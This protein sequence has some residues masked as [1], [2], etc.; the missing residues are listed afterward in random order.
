MGAEG[1]LSVSTSM[2]PDARAPQPISA[3]PALQRLIIHEPW[4]ANPAVRA[5][6]V[7]EAEGWEGHR[8]AFFI[9][10]N[11]RCETL[12]MLVRHGELHYCRMYSNYAL[13]AV[14]AV[15]WAR[16]IK[17]E[18]E[19]DLLSG[20]G[21]YAN[22]QV[23]SVRVVRR[24]RRWEL[25]ITHGGLIPLVADFRKR[26]HAQIAAEDWLTA[27]HHDDEDGEGSPTPSSAS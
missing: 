26:E 13:A 3:F 25:H 11:S 19:R 14:D 7:W 5:Q 12:A 18:P 27:S 23:W 22:G 16:E 1:G 4:L 15:M 17:L 9:L 24:L 2:D 20:G 10:S 21:V 6:R 8:Y